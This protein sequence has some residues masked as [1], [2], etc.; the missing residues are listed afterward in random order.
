MKTRKNSADPR[1]L[2][3]RV[4][5]H[6]LLAGTLAMLAAATAAA[7][8]TFASDEDKFTGDHLR[9]RT[10][11]NG[12]TA[13]SGDTTTPACAPTGSRVA[14]NR[15]TAD[16]LFVRFLEI[17]DEKDALLNDTDRAGLAAC[18]KTS[19]VNGFTQYRIAKSALEQHAFRRSGVTFGGLLVPFKYRLGN[20]KELVSSS[21]MA[22][23]V[24]FR[25]AWFQN[26]GLSFT[27]VLA[28]GLSLV[29]VTDAGSSTTST[30]AA[31]TLALGARLTS[32]KNEAFSAGLLFGR[33][34]LSKSDRALDPNV[35]KPWLSF[36]VGFSI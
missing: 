33:D 2:F 28:A 16:D 15:E 20:A 9:F 22:P 14:V 4:A 7:E 24:G 11:V 12:F 1:R 18:P 21:A 34:F 8:P 17:T 31:Y 26:W 19:R 5:L 13:V 6:A 36:Y 35:S 27:P 10:N 23:F 3:S 29:P 25:T 30:R 32:S